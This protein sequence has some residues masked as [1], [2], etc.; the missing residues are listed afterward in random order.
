MRGAAYIEYN[1][2]LQWS[3]YL[4]GHVFYSLVWNDVPEPLP[5]LLIAG[6]QST[7]DPVFH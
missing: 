2:A 7:E 6:A 3:K 1:E 5:Y 4:F